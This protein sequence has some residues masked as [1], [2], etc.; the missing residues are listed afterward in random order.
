MVLR[1]VVE[2]EFIGLRVVCGCK[3]RRSFCKIF[4][5]I[6]I[7]FKFADKKYCVSNEEGLA[8]YCFSSDSLD[9]FDFIS[10]SGGNEVAHDDLV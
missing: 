8:N 3:L 7:V 10:L 5:C 4:F 2:G 1:F 9:R 6:S